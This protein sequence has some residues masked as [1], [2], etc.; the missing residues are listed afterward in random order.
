MKILSIISLGVVL[1]NLATAAQGQTLLAN[2]Q[3]DQYSGGTTWTDAEG[4]LTASLYLPGTTPVANGTSVSTNGGFYFSTDTAGLTG[5]TSYSLAVGFTATAI[6][7]GAGSPYAFSGNGILGGDI[8]GYGQGDIGLSVSVYDNGLIAGG[9]VSGGDTGVEDPGS[10]T[11]NFS[12][13]SPTGAVIVVQGSTGGSANGSISLYVNGTLAGQQTGLTTLPVGSYNFGIGTLYA[14]AAYP[15][16]G[17]ITQAQIYSGALTATAAEAL[18]DSISEDSVPE[19]G[20][21]ALVLAGLLPMAL[22]CRRLRA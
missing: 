11:G 20:A 19:P 12:L 18:S 14:G 10:P 15:F 4:T 21:W 2:F 8:S 16:S 17:D 22:G 9:G 7:N 6:Y 1:A 3:A 13:N 5:L